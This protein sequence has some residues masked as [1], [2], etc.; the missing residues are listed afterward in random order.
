MDASDETQ[1]PIIDKEFEPNRFVVARLVE[2]ARSSAKRVVVKL[3]EGEEIEVAPNG[4]PPGWSF[5]VD[6]LVT[7]DL[8]TSAALPLVN[9]EHTEVGH[10]WTALT[11]TGRRGRVVATRADRHG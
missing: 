1:Q 9:G 8:D 10:R 11:A 7:V 3:Q 6:E 5:E 2:Q 4:F